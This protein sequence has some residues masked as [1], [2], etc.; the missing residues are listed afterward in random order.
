MSILKVSIRQIKAARALLGWSQDDLATQS[1]VSVPTVKRLEAAD[2][3][4]GGRAET[5]DALVAALE[6][7]GV[8]F[9][10][11]NGGGAGV[12]MRKRKR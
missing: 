6:K 11:E 10:P 5:G 7:A 12:R 8:E 1:G 2:G 3:E 9:I 4:V